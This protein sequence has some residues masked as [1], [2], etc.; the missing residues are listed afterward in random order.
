[1]RDVDHLNALN[2][3]VLCD[4]TPRFPTQCIEKGIPYDIEALLVVSKI[5]HIQNP[6]LGQKSMIFCEMCFRKAYRLSVLSE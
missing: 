6:S 4:Y 5:I 2:T 3:A 1:M